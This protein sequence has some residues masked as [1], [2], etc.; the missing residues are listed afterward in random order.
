MMNYR[1]K[2]PVQSIA[3]SAL[4]VSAFAGPVAAKTENKAST[5]SPA[6]AVTAPGMKELKLQDPLKIAKK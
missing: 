2:K 5:T 6:K 4:M 3:L 1:T